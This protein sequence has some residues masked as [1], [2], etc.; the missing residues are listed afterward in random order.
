MCILCANTENTQSMLFYNNE[1]S[2]TGLLP[3]WQNL[4]LRLQSPQSS[5][6]PLQTIKLTLRQYSLMVNDSLLQASKQHSDDIKAAFQSF[7]LIHWFVCP[8]AHVWWWRKM[9][10]E[11]SKVYFYRSQ[12]RS[13]HIWIGPADFPP[14]MGEVWFLGLGAK[15]EARSCLLYTSPSP[16]D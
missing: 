8:D 7:N 16:R 4:W 15:L 10:T 14:P 5:S 13:S 12:A 9:L 3:V 1:S 6:Y 11:F 2:R